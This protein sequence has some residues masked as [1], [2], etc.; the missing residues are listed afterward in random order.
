MLDMVEYFVKN[1]IAQLPARYVLVA[2]NSDMSAP[3]G[4]NDAPQTGMVPYMTTDILKSEYEK[5]RL[6]AF[7]AQN[8][9]W[10]NYSTTPRPKY[11]HCIP[12]G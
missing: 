10:M 4:Q 6:L 2:H 8:L 9:W 3:D 1:K 12:I 7:H 5:G 11:I